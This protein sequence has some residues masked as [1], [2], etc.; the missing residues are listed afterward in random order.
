MICLL[1]EKKLIHHKCLFDHLL[2]SHHSYITKISDSTYFALKTST[3]LRRIPSHNTMSLSAYVTPFAY[4][5][6]SY[7]TLLFLTSKTFYI[8]NAV[9]Q[10]FILSK[11]L[12]TN[13]SDYGYQV[14]EVVLQRSELVFFRG[15]TQCFLGNL[16][17]KSI[18]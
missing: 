3:L 16:G 2:K 8:A 1:K 5:M 15:R 4:R 6:G 12:G 7:L 14:R 17:E 10:L 11:V 18:I 13:F 9:G